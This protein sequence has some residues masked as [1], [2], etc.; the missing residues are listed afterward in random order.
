MGKEGECRGSSFRN[1]LPE[2]GVLAPKIGEHDATM[3]QIKEGK[4]LVEERNLAC[5]REPCPPSRAPGKEGELNAIDVSEKKR[6]STSR[7]FGKLRKE[8]EKAVALL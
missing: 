8:G 6:V 1:T 4:C 7:R 2:R 3:R 5:D